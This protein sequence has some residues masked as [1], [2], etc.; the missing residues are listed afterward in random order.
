MAFQVITSPMFTAA[1]R[2]NDT[3]LK[4]RLRGEKNPRTLRRLSS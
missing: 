3:L 1:I 4:N 2:V